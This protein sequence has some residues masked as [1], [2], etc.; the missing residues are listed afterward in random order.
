MALN[1]GDIAFVQYNAD[2]TDD[3]AFVVLVNILA[4]EEILFTD[5]GWLADNSGFRSGE[6]IL[7]WTA[8]AGGIVAGTVVTITNDSTP[9]VSVGTVSES[10]SFS[11]STSGDQIIAY[12]DDGTVTPIAAINNQESSF[13]ADATS[14]LTSALPQ[15]LTEGS[16]A[17]AIDEVD[18]VAYSGLT[19]G[20]QATLQAALND[21]NNWTN[22]SNSARQTFSGSFNGVG[23][24]G[25]DN[26]SIGD[27]VWN[28]LDGDGVQ[29]GGES[30][31]DNVTIN[32][33][34][35]ANSSGTI[36]AGDILQTTVTTTGGGAFDF[37]GLAAGD[38]I[39]DVTDTNN[40]LNGFT[41]TGGT[42]PLAVTLSADEDFN[43]AD[44]GYQSNPGGGGGSSITPEQ[45]IF[46][47]EQ[48]VL[49]EA[50]EEGRTVPFNSVS[51]GGIPIAKLFDETY[52]LANNPGVAAA[53]NGGFFS[54]GYEHFVT[55]GWREGRN[56]SSLYNEA[57]YL[58][59]NPNVAAAVN[60]NFFSSGFEH[61]ILFGHT[62]DR[63]PSQLF[64]ASDY[65]LNNTDVANAVTANAFSSGFQHFTM[66]GLQGGRSP[67][68]LL[69]NEVFYLSEN[70]SVAN[71]VNAGFF[72]SGFEHYLLFG[73]GEGRS[74]SSL[75]NESSYLAINTDVAG[76]VNADFFT[77]GFE[78]YI[79]FGR[80][81]GRDVTMAYT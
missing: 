42:D 16:S 79:E 68:L 35:D 62:E 14:T 32:L 40:V 60:A 7:T 25:S 9:T 71:A 78:H 19:T 47:F 51:M 18:N 45:G 31:I 13:Q 64:D 4:G 48:Y 75:F 67:D 65:L 17:V 76:A 12:Q 36:D 73:Q 15:G 24:G 53:V 77:S 1:P 37:T 72:E 11:L 74:P 57:F 66:F 21:S 30:G 50:M 63:D 43:D 44:F 10:G 29:D 23:G 61:F 22:S 54:S 69:F 70:N 52:Y 81:A 27:F 34:E 46:T 3:F 8:P 38:Y 58:A 80:A 55:F 28:D 26:G 49:F 6:G 56:P 59:A 2:G 20:D 39:I 33:Y 41:L 5:N